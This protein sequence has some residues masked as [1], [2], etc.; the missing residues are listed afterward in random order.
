LAIFSLENLPDQL[1]FDHGLILQD[2]LK[3]RQEWLSRCSEDEAAP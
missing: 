2:Y 1:A 3:V